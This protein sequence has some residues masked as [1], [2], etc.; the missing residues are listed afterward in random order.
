MILLMKCFNGTDH[1]PIWADSFGSGKSSKFGASSSQDL[2]HLT[3]FADFDNLFLKQQSKQE[4]MQT[5]ERTL[6]S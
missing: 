3:E 5:F 2:W 4:N 1:N 6:I